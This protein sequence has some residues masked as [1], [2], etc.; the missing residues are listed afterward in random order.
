MSD[1]TNLVKLENINDAISEKGCEIKISEAT[2]NAFFT[3]NDKKSA[4]DMM[5]YSE[6]GNFSRFIRD[7]KYG[8]EC[9]IMFENQKDMRSAYV[10]I[11]NVRKEQAKCSYIT[12][13]SKLSMF[14]KCIKNGEE[15]FTL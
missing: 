2:I 7:M 12:K 4:C 6:I 11:S 5:N 9:I 13:T 3:V 10:L 8:Y 14:L 15:G 1:N